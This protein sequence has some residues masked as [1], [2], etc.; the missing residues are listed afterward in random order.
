MKWLVPFL[1][2]TASLIG[3]IVAS[4][5]ISGKYF[6]KIVY[7]APSLHYGIPFSA[8]MNLCPISKR[9]ENLFCW[10][11]IDSDKKIVHKCFLNLKERFD[12]GKCYI[13]EIGRY[14]N[15][16]LEN[17]VT[18]EQQYCITMGKR[19]IKVENFLPILFLY[20]SVEYLLHEINKRWIFS[21]LSN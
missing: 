15:S 21:I 18:K 14:I 4:F 3:T 20:Y 9:K 6:C 10:K 5:N 7:P 1:K 11:A 16:S 13:W 8:L 12:T 17:L 2:L 19:I